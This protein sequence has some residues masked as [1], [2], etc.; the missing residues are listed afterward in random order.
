VPYCQIP[1][2][3]IDR[4]KLFNGDIVI[5]RTGATTGACLHIANPPLA[6]FAS[7]LVRF[8]INKTLADSRYIYYCLKS[9]SFNAYL[10]GVLGDKSAQPNASAYTMTQFEIDIPPLE[11]Q[12]EIAHILGTLDD[13]IEQ[14]RSMNKTLE[15]IAQALFKHWFIDFEF[16]NADGKPYKSS[17]GAMIDSELGPIPHGWKVGKL[18]DVCLVSKEIVNP[19]KST[20][21][22]Y[23]YYSIPAYDNSQNPDKVQLKTIMSNKYSVPN[24]CVL[25][26]RLNP[27]TKRIWYVDES[28]V[29]K[30]CSTE[31]YVL[32]SKSYDPLYIYLTLSEPQYYDTLTSSVNGTSN[33]HQRLD[34]DSLLDLSIVQPKL[35]Q[36]KSIILLTQMYKLINNNKKAIDELQKVRLDCMN[37]L[38]N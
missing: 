23:L 19:L 26:S 21:D 28:Y 17:G 15:E 11:T 22:S 16:P 6:V 29:N 9:D 31:F 27:T 18:R 37:Y 35:D 25:F 8:K 24:N 30:L 13:K 38:L 5:A 3:D 36:D 32:E 33:S 1:K 7:Y 2:K 34:V 10:Q 20:D 12:K 14:N 4:Y